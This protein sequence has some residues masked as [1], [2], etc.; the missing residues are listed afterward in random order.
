MYVKS[1]YALTHMKTCMYRVHTR[2]HNLCCVDM[3]K[4]LG[5]GERVGARTELG[6]RVG[7]EECAVQSLA[8]EKRNFIN[9]PQTNLCLSRL[10]PFPAPL[11]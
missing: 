5:F 11:R 1:I 8:C 7:T 3:W 6:K 10:F 9:R 2:R 4:S